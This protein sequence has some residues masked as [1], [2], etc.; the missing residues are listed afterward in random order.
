MKNII[1]VVRMYPS[2]QEGKSRALR[3]YFPKKVVEILG[4]S[5]VFDLNTLKI[6]RAE[7]DDVKTFTIGSLHTSIGVDD[8]SYY[9][10]DYNL[11]QV[12]EDNFKLK[13]WQKIT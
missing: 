7:I 10:G 3:I 4:N 2:S 13:K 5:I 9:F 6:R 1:G 11:I 8:P 12:D